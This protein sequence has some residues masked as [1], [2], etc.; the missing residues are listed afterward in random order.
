ML[1]KMISLDKAIVVRL[2]TQGETFEIFV[3]PNLA[4]DYKGGKDISLDNILAAYTIF[5]DARAG[6]R[7]SNES[8]IKIFGTS[9]V[10]TAA[11]KI[12]KKGELHLTTEQKRQMLEARK[13]Q[14]V[15]IISR[16]AINPQTK[17][18][19][20][21]ARIE[22]ALE[23]VRFN[24]DISKSANE[25]IDSAVK[26]IRPILPIRFGTVEV[27]VK[28]P[29]AYAGNCHRILQEFGDIKKE[30]WNGGDLLCILEIP[31]GVQD[32]FYSKINGLTHGEAEI[33]VLR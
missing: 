29:A 18:P 2:K 24:I 11:D 4:L 9:D 14:I 21:P 3:D 1:D 12:L 32:E 30:E 19:H 7:A 16:K 27:A 15:A 25:Q 8:M 17:T 33:K 23:E 20:P 31:G 5:K 22:K 13:K 28:I 26:E 10:N 6:D